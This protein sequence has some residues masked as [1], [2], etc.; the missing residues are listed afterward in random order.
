MD[1]KHKARKRKPSSKHQHLT[2]L[3]P[4]TSP[5][6][7]Y[8]RK[9]KKELV[10]RDDDD[11]TPIAQ[12]VQK[13]SLSLTPKTP[14]RH[15]PVTSG[16]SSPSTAP[17]PG[18]DPIKRSPQEHLKKHHQRSKRIK[19]HSQSAQATLPKPQATEVALPS[20][21]FTD[22]AT[23]SQENISP[24]EISLSNFIVI[25]DRQ[26][27][28]MQVFIPEFLVNCHQNK[29]TCGLSFEIRDAVLF[30]STRQTK[31]VDS[32]FE[33]HFTEITTAVQVE[34][35]SIDLGPLFT[36]EAL[37]KIPNFLPPYDITTAQL[38]V[39]DIICIVVDMTPV[40][41]RI[42]RGRLVKFVEAYITDPTV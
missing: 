10:F 35:L 24:S 7:H 39:K 17:L 5:S 27:L 9:C 22:F 30:R 41:Q 29:F 12:L 4:A 26:G 28:L 21:Q 19:I 38:S 31:L 2:G 37:A 1:P 11:D 40:Q 33:L 32:A 36:F 16:P 14:K 25:K 34:N 42:H 3:P 13:T 8:Q 15:E 6:V 23:M 20:P 18:T